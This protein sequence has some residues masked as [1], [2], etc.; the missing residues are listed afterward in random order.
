MFMIQRS[1]TKMNLAL[2]ATGKRGRPKKNLVGPSN[3]CNG[4][5]EGC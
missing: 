2:K 1:S 3:I 4:V 5:D